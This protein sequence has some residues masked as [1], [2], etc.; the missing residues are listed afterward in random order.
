MRYLIAAVISTIWLPVCGQ[1]TSS[2][3]SVP[4]YP[5]RH[6]RDPLGIPISLAANFGELRPDHYHMGL[7][8]RTQHR[9]NLP[10]Y[11]AADGYVARVQIGP[12]GFGQA[13]YVRHPGGYTTVY[14]HLNR[15]FPAL[16]AYVKQQQ[17]RQQSWQVDLNI[18][19]TLFPVMQGQQI[20]WSGNTGGSQG[21]HLHFEI[22]LT[23]EGVNL[24]PLLFGL[25]VE[26]RVAPRISGLAWYDGNEGVYDQQ[27]HILP[28]QQGRLPAG[29]VLTVPVTR[30]CFAI[31]ASD[32]QSGSS[33]P[34]G[35]Y[36]AALYDGNRAVIGF[37][38][39]R[40]SYEDTRNI[41]AHIDYKTRIMGGPFLQQLFFLPGYPFPSI[42]RVPG[43]NGGMDPAA[44]HPAG[45]WKAGSTDGLIDLGD[46][47]PH[48][49][50]IEVSDTRGNKTSLAFAVQY[51][52]GAVAP[53]KVPAIDSA[54]IAEAAGTKEYY[55]G[56]V[57]GQETA[58][59]AFFL[60]ERSLYD[61]ANI[62]VTVGTGLSIPG[63]VT[64]VYAIGPR[65]IPLLDPVLVRLRLSD[66]PSTSRVVMVCFDGSEMDVQLPEWTGAWA[67]AR[68][69]EFG[70]FQLVSDTIPPVITPVGPLEGADLR[71][72]GGIALR[73]RDNL[74]APRHFRAEL[75]GHWI[76]FTNDKGLAYI[77][78]FDEHCMPGLHTLHVTV[79]DIAGNRTGQEYHFHR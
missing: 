56:M 69:R 36:R 9:E 8:I 50:R 42:Y 49:I 43:P 61:S 51:R 17:Y 39:D 26:D 70:N 12:F 4:D 19:S 27:P 33:N 13:I 30:I 47:R 5:Q 25:P 77:Y 74:G 71:H 79:E 34:N 38:L 28:V 55:P 65:W 7:D 24:N 60:G 63:G 35:I 32:A 3:F 78:K 68:F 53:G 66:S 64:P 44:A 54:S 45:G 20:A 58:D 57:D 10:V 48:D 2:L 73:V 37:Q 76:C 6:F 46:G 31:S 41:N 21:P 11:A 23:D 1:T 72:A 22:R 29:A 62:G 15:F 67:S 40:I 52:S 18:P 59:Y 75:D 14:G 16:A